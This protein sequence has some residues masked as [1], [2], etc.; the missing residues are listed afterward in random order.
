MKSQLP[1]IADTAEARR[2][3]EFWRV[4][5]EI[6]RVYRELTRKGRE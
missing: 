2:I 6:E 4:Q 5:L 1:L 3:R